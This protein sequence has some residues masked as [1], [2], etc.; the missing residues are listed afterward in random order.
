MTIWH[1][2]PVADLLPDVLLSAVRAHH[3]AEEQLKRRKEELA[4][5]IADAVKDGAKLSHVARAA[6]Y[7]PEHVRRIARAHGVEGDPSRVPPPP[8]PRRR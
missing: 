7:T 2:Q 4:Q 1:T 8:P 3:R 6:G 5:A